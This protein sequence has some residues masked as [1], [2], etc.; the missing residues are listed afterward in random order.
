MDVLR[1]INSKDIRKHLESIGYEFTS[2]EAA[3]LIR[4][5]RSAAIAEKHAAWEE[6]IA[7]AP[8]CEIPPRRIST[9]Y[10]LCSIRRRRIP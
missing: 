4:R 2:L 7:A 10:R 1:F 8:D 6:L 9:P 5:C 3:W